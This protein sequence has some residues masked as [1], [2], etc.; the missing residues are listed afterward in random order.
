MKVFDKENSHSCSFNE[1]KT[2]RKDSL[3]PMLINIEYL[4]GMNVKH[5]YY[6]IIILIDKKKKEG[7]QFFDYLVNKCQTNGLEY[8]FYK[9]FEN[10][11][12]IAN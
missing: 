7:Y 5:W 9:P 6:V 2:S 8:L 12:R 1:T 11:F 10:A 3:K 4:L